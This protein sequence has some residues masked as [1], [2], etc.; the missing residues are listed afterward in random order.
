VERFSGCP[1]QISAIAVFFLLYI[2]LNMNSRQLLSSALATVVALGLTQ[3]VAAHMEKGAKGKDKCYGVAKV[4]ENSCTN[5]SGTHGC[6]GEADTDNSPEEWK[7]V[8]K[9]TCAKLGGMNEKQATAAFAKA[10]A[11]TA[12][13]PT[14]KGEATPPAGK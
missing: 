6:A 14:P 7:L 8:P 5:L 12:I 1:G 11:A 9:G 2:E 10:K 3:P 13:Q 4:G